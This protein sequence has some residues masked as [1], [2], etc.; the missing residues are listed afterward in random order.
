ML[1]LSG[2]ELYS[3]W[4]PLRDQ[5][6]IYNYSNGFNFRIMNSLPV[7]DSCGIRLTWFD[8]KQMKIADREV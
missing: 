5:S 4:V 8:W 7:T 3:R 6:E 2:F 1:C